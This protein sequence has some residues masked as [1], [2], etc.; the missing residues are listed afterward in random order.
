MGNV[1]IFVY[2]YIPKTEIYG[3][4]IG[5]TRRY[6]FGVSGVG[7]GFLRVGEMNDDLGFG[8][9]FAYGFGGSA[10][11]MVLVTLTPWI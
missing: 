6:L 1:C 7:A 3:Y 11:T 2:L 10:V 5:Y 8:E 9:H 4:L